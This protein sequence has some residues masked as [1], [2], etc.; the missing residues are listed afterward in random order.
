MIGDTVSWL[1]AVCPRVS[2][3]GPL[4]VHQH[5]RY[6][7]VAEVTE[8]GVLVEPLLG[9]FLVRS[10]DDGVTLN[11]GSGWQLRDLYVTLQPGGDLPVWLCDGQY[12][13]EDR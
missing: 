9:G 13:P 10:R 5:R 6:G 3:A 7:R 1:V 4:V 8:G 11:R 12:R 2:D